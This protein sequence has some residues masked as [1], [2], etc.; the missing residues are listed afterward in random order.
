M[1]GA[2]EVTTTVKVD[3]PTAPEPDDLM[4][5]IWDAF[6]VV[7]N[8]YPGIVRFSAMRFINLTTGLEIEQTRPLVSGPT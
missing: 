7:E 6:R 2:I 3:Q 1:M 5:D 4:Q 8:K